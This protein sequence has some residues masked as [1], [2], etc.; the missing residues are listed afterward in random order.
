MFHQVVQAELVDREDAVLGAGLDRHVRD[1]EAVVHREVLD[2]G[3]GEL[4]RLVTRAVDADETD[5][6]ED[7]VL[8]RDPLL[9]LALDD[10]LDRAR[11]LEPGLA[12]AHA[13][14]HVRRTDARRERAHGAVGAGMGVRADDA[15]TGCDES[16]LRQER[17][18]DAAVVSD[19]E[20]V[21]DLLVL[22]EGAHAG[23][24]GR[25]LDV[26]VRREV[27]R[28]ER[29]LRLVEDLLLAELRKLADRDGRGDV[30][31]QHEVELRHDELARV[32]FLHP[33]VFRQDLLRHCHCHSTS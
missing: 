16:L 2:A 4:E 23:A 10:D 32:D 26:L 28:N 9:R 8:A 7:Q 21:L 19:L 22:C 30:I 13:G 33:G 6:V 24:L 17:V 18:F 29:D 3:T 27:V 1:R 11:N 12:R 15:V 5:E 31:A 25:R 20:V 14:G